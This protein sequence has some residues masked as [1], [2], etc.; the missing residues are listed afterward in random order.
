MTGPWNVSFPPNLG[1]PENVQLTELESWTENANEGVKYFSG[2]AA[3]NKTVVA[4]Q[5]WFRPGVKIVLNL[6]MVKDIAEVSVNGKALG[7]LWKEPYQVDVTNTLKSG[8]N[9]LEIKVTN[10]WTNRL[11]GDYSAPPDKKVLTPSGPMMRGFGRPQ[12]PAESG[13]LGPVTLVSKETR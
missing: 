11:A 8:A 4:L 5:S 2:T 6:G 7:T 12:Q 9:Q 1:A 3:Y 13:L 10:Q